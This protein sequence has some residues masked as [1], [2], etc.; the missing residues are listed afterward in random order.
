MECVLFTRQTD[1]QSAPVKVVFAEFIVLIRFVGIFTS[2]SALYIHPAYLPSRCE[3][4]KLLGHNGGIK[5]PLSKTKDAV[6]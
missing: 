2:L 4:W 1:W 6:S 3:L 5:E